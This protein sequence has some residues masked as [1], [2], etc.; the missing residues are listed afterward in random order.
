MQEVIGEPDTYTIPEKYETRL[1]NLTLGVSSSLPGFSSFELFTEE[2][3]DP[4]PLS[5][6][7]VMAAFRDWL[8][9]GT[10]ALADG[11]CAGRG[12]KGRGFSTG[13]AW[14][15]IRHNLFLWRTIRILIQRQATEN[16]QVQ[17]TTWNSI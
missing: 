10:A 17:A 6:F 7:S 16:M 4:Y 13:L 2:D 8:R 1:W 11:S 3:M 9:L 12:G 14:K 5:S 15:Q